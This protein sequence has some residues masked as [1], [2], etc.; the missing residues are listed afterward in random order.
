MFLDLSKDAFD[1]VPKISG[2]DW[3]VLIPFFNQREHLPDTIESLARQAT[4]FTLVLVDNGSTDDS[5]AVAEAACRAHRLDYMLLTERMPGKV[6]ALRAGLAWV[7]TRWVAMCEANIGYPSHYL[8]AAEA[9]LSQPGHVAAG[10]Y[11]IAPEAGEAGRLLAARRFLAAVRLLP[12]QCHAGN[13]GMTFCTRSLRAAGGFDAARWNFVLEDREVAHRVM[14][15]GRMGY[16][17]AL[18]CTPSRYE[19]ERGPAG[20]TPFERLLYSAT[21][22]IAADWFFYKFL[23]RRLQRRRL[24]SDRSCERPNQHLEGPAFA[25]SRSL[26]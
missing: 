26:R 10:A 14:R 19:R 9:I 15:K 18:W 5:A 21:A 23:A 24:L 20:W 7:R 16:S 6:A 22:P 11:F 25:P 4:R 12:R 1:D 8:E 13:G 2:P 3:T 17:D